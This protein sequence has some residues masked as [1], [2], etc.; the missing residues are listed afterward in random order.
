MT[1]SELDKL[2]D[3]IY[4]SF[5]DIQTLDLQQK[6]YFLNKLSLKLSKKEKPIYTI[7]DNLVSLYVTENIPSEYQ[8][9]TRSALND[10]TSYLKSVNTSPIKANE[11]DIKGFLKNQYETGKSQSA[12]RV[13]FSRIKKF[14]QYLETNN[15]IL[16]E[17][18][19]FNFVNVSDVEYKHQT[20]IPTEEDIHTILN[21]LDINL[22]VFF[23][24]IL[25]K[26]FQKD[27][28]DGLSFMHSLLETAETG[29]RIPVTYCFVD[30]FL[31]DFE[32]NRN[33]EILYSDDFFQ[34]QNFYEYI[35]SP[36]WYID[37]LNDFWNKVLRFQISD[38]EEGPAPGELYYLNNGINIDQYEKELLKVIKK[39]FKQ[40]KISFSYRMKD[41]YLYA[42]INL[43]NRTHN[44][45]WVQKRLGHT[46]PNTTRRYLQNAGIKIE[47]EKKV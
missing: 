18:N 16:H 34:V 47:N 22:K 4:Q 19:P 44:L 29:G 14:Y 1:N 39:L 36:K 27:A 35:S 17:N 42:I 23:A 33:D 10:I 24:I 31:W 26:G 46:N 7:P 2:I 40:G 45:K 20:I 12:V 43:Y 6:K 13:K 41:F 11:N 3:S 21:S 30:E 9:V 32:R 37:L 8:K 28:F 5:P 25:V 15:Y 38:F